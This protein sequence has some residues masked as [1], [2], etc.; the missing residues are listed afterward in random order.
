[1]LWGSVVLSGLPNRS[2]ALISE[3]W[4]TTANRAYR[5]LVSSRSK[6]FD[7]PDKPMTRRKTVPRGVRE[8]KA[9]KAKRKREKDYGSARRSPRSVTFRLNIN[10]FWIVHIAVLPDGL[11]SLSLLHLAENN[12]QQIPVH[13][14][15]GLQTQ[16]MEIAGTILI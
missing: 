16:S 15:F 11:V 9:S 1:M 12:E 3:C 10:E 8:E 7:H 5:F 6:N 2:H 4:F 13:P 14:S